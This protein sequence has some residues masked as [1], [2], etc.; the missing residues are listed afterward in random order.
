MSAHTKKPRTKA[1]ADYKLDEIMYFRIGDKVYGI[2]KA[3]IGQYLIS[4][5]PANK[6]IAIAD[7]ISAEDLFQEIDQQYT[8]AGALLKGLRIRESLTQ[9]QFAERINVT[10]TNLS[11]ME[12]GK[13]AIGKDVA[14]R[15]A[16]Q[17][18]VDYRYFL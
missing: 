3:V 6:K 12:N 8:K 10:Q 17:F 9:V 2:P 13:R 4:Q 18:S 14:K 15:I 11:S 7:T 16:E 1:K 5:L